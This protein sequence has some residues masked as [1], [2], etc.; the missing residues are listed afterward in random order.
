MFIAGKSR[1]TQNIYYMAHIACLKLF[2]SFII[3]SCYYNRLLRENR[4]SR[5]TL[6]STKIIE[7]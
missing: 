4:A 1:Y 5:V 3:Y 7:Q 2:P 6:E